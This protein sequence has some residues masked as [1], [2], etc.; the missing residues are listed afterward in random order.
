MYE[1][2]VRVYVSKCFSILFKL[3]LTIRRPALGW[4]LAISQEERLSYGIGSPLYAWRLRYFVD[5][6]AFKSIYFFI[7]LPASGGIA[8]RD[9]ESGTLA[10]KSKILLANQN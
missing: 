6:G 3:H 5:L 9:V 8:S 1:K 7:M 10:I 2:I 4:P